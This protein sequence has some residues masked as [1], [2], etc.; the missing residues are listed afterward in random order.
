MIYG[1]VARGDSV[2]SSD[3]DVL[4]V[5]DGA[6]NADV[7]KTLGD[8]PL[9]LADHAFISRT[10]YSWEQMETMAT[11]GSLFLRHL[12]D[13]GVIVGE[14]A[15]NERLRFL[16]DGIPEYQRARND[17]TGFRCAIQ[18]VL[19]SLVDTRSLEFE[20]SAVATTTRH[21]SILGSY[22]FGQ[23]HYSVKRSI[24]ETTG[25]VG[26]TDF[27]PLALEL[28]AWRVAHV[29]QKVGLP[30]AWT[31]TRIHDFATK[32]LTMIGHLECVEGGTQ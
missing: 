17:L 15:A 23:V 3:L 2:A 14:T 27:A 18:D 9:A 13:E 11:Y 29:R 25:H 1:S 7:E 30:A 10:Q 32:S 21:A 26:M 6:P 31:R 5:G 28:Y 16:L 8:S 22:L 24:Q 12:R 4:L 19:E 20:A